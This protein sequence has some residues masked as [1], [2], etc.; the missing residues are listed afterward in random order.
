[1]SNAKVLSVEALEQFF[2]QLKAFRT[3]LMKE[4]EALELE[5]RRLTNFIEVDATR[6]WEH[7]YQQ[8]RRKLSEYSQQLSRCMSYVR[9]DER[10]PCTEEKKMVAKAKER[11][12]LCENKMQIAQAARQHWESR[13]AKVRTKLQRGR[14]LAE[15]E[16]QVAINKLQRILEN[17]EDYRRVA[18]G[19]FS[20]EPAAD[21]TNAVPI[22]LMEQ[23]SGNNTQIS[24]D[25]SDKFRP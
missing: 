4:L 10:K 17:L 22:E 24:E 15:S 2:V 13:K 18:S 7:E 19:A 1:M 21:T 25:K 11:T 6:Y 3:S 12:Q 14:D 16:L 8:V 9:E 23:D 5:L 20:Q